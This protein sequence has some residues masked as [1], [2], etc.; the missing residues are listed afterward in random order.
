M[1]VG[2]TN[3]ALGNLQPQL[4][5]VANADEPVYVRRLRGPISVI[6][7]K[8]HGV[9]LTASYAW[10]GRKVLAHEPTTR[11]TIAF[12]PLSRPHEVCVTVEPVVS[13]RVDAATHPAVASE[14]ASDPILDRKGRQWLHHSTHRASPKSYR[15]YLGD[16]CFN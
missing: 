10:M 3:I 7:I 1:T 6:E 13:P 11:F 9:S 8:N 16:R 12:V 5:Y 15:R 4:L 14:R 2:A